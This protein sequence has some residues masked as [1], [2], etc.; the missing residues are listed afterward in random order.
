MCTSF[1]VVVLLLV[2]LLWLLAVAAG[3]GLDV[4]EAL[5][6]GLTWDAGV[7]SGDGGGDGGGGGG[8]FASVGDTGVV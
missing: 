3:C 8:V 7:A 4:P 2:C 1:V 6:G 5:V